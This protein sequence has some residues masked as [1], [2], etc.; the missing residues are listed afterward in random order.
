MVQGRQP[1]LRGR[2]KEFQVALWEEVLL[3][4]T[5]SQKSSQKDPWKSLSDISPVR[6]LGDYRTPGSRE[7]SW[8]WARRN[9]WG[10]PLMC[11]VEPETYQGAR[12]RSSARSLPFVMHL[13]AWVEVG[14]GVGVDVT[15]PRSGWRQARSQG[16]QVP[17]DSR[18][19]VTPS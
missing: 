8:L 19:W 11:A 4:A 18:G 3:G 15:S 10:I 9:I 16:W 14:V 5:Q 1:L 12:S 7:S 13:L 6:N 2:I 17:W